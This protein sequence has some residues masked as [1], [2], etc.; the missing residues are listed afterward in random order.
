MITL[1]FNCALDRAN[2]VN[3][4]KFNLDFKVDNNSNILQECQI[5]DNK[6]ITTIIE[7]VTKEKLIDLDNK[8]HSDIL[9]INSHNKCLDLKDNWYY[10]GNADEVEAF[11]EIPLGKHAKNRITFLIFKQNIGWND[12]VESFIERISNPIIEVIDEDEEEEEK[13]PVKEIKRIKAANCIACFED[14]PQVM[15]DCGHKPFCH[16][17]AKLWKTSCPICRE[18]PKIIFIDNEEKK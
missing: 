9:L 4:C 7:H 8:Y 13:E 16:D 6:W 10:C 17:C 3:A 5:Y 2:F 14:S 18:Q 1:V 15:F 11:M 12:V